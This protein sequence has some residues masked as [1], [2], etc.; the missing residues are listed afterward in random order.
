M[1]YNLLPVNI[2]KSKSELRLKQD[3][4]FLMILKINQIIKDKQN[5]ISAIP[6][7]WSSYVALRKK[8]KDIVSFIKG[9]SFIPVSKPEVKNNSYDIEKY[10]FVSQD[11]RDMIDAE[12]SDIA[13]DIYIAET[14]QIMQDWLQN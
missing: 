8:N 11:G 6:L 13:E 2:L 5:T 10:R 12:L 14:M 7:Q 1:P 9:N 4:A 3:S